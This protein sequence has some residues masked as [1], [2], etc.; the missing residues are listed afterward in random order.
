MDKNKIEIKELEEKIA[1]CDYL[2][3]YG[4][5]VNATQEQTAKAFYVKGSLEEELRVLKMRFTDV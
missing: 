3:K 1:F 5:L 2:I 4:S